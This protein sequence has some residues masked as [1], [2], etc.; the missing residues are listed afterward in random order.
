MEK[1]RIVFM[2]PFRR[3]SCYRSHPHTDLAMDDQV[4][5]VVLA[6]LAGIGRLD[7]RRGHVE[8]LQVKAGKAFANAAGG[9]IFGGSTAGVRKESE[10]LLRAAG[11]ALGHSR[12]ASAREVQSALIQRGHRDLARDVERTVRGRNSIA[13]PSPAPKRHVLAALESDQHP[14]VKGP[15]VPNVHTEEDSHVPVSI[16]QEEVASTKDP[17]LAFQ[18]PLRGGSRPREP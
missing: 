15:C 9:S 12:A 4:A 14:E 13:H 16:T 17:H 18:W 6:Q 5:S 11:A 1:W 7:A 3:F 2:N 8:W 10:D